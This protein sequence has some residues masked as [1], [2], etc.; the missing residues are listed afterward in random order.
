MYLKRFVQLFVIFFVSLVIFA[1]ILEMNFGNFWLRF[2]LGLLVAYIFLTLPLVLLTIFKSNRKAKVVGTN[3]SENELAYLLKDF[4]GYLALSVTDESLKSSTTIMSFIQAQKN[5]NVLYMV[6]D[7][8]A[9]KI[10]DLKKNPLV[11]FTT[12]F[13]SLENGGRLSSNRVKSEVLEGEAA[14][15]LIK[16]EPLILSLHENAENMSI[17]R[18]TIES[19]LYENFKGQMKVIEFEK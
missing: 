2:A 1:L 15:K 12:W 8:K 7:K 11:S 17:I 4:P 9:S 16:E 10:Y 19:V 18:L 5:E 13:D 14:Q 6:S 3:A